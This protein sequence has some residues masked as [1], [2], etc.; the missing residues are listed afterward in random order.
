MGNILNSIENR[1]ITPN[2]IFMKDYLNIDKIDALKFLNEDF[3]I[4]KQLF[5]SFF[6]TSENYFNFFDKEGK[7]LINLWEIFIIIF[8]LKT[9]TY[10]SKIHRIL[11][12]FSF[13]SLVSEEKFNF[14]NTTINV[15]DKNINNLTFD[16]INFIFD[17]F[18]TVIITLFSY[19]LNNEE[20]SNLVESKDEY[21]REIVLLEENNSGG[22]KIDIMIR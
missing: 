2:I 18:L 11:E 4:D 8:L 14:Q 3:F 12:I 17:I 10:K 1:N 20:T 6:S 19:D 7:G 13:S 21:L 5:C 22:V 9:D 15:E 16:E